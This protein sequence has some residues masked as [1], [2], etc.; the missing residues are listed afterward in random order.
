MY[1]VYGV[2]M[3]A[4]LVFLYEFAA[5]KWKWLEAPLA[6]IDFVWFV[7]LTVSIWRCAMNSGWRGWGVLARLSIV[8]AWAGY[9]WS[10]WRLYVISVYLAP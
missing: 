6:I 3:V 8:A 10:A 4:I 1:W 7:W 9:L 5:D 2:G